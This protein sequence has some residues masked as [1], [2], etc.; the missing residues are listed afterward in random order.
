MNGI[1]VCNVCVVPEFWAPRK[2]GEDMRTKLTIIDETPENQLIREAAEAEKIANDAAIEAA[3]QAALGKKPMSE[4]TKVALKE[5]AESRKAM[6]KA[7]K[8]QFDTEGHPE[9]RL[10]KGK[11]KIPVFQDLLKQ[12]E[13]CAK[14]PWVIAG[15][16][17]QDPEKS[18]GTLLA[19][20][21][22][23]CGDENRIIHLADAFHTKLCKACK[24]NGGKSK[25]DKQSISGPSGEPGPASDPK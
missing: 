13:I 5:L 23:N 19:I 2:T 17:T 21:C 18:G 14:F 12:A 16:F 4:E 7:I 24:K 1:W 6:K 15:T 10:V 9:V 3:R 22:G 11:S 8:E 20:K 25:L